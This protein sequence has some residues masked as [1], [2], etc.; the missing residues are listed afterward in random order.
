MSRLERGLAGPSS[1]KGEHS[2]PALCYIQM[3]ICHGT[4]VRNSNRA[5]I[6]GS[7]MARYVAAHETVRMELASAIGVSHAAIGLK[8]LERNGPQAHPPP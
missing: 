1:A 2:D 3:V 4:E 7:S 5:R 8:Y 6:V